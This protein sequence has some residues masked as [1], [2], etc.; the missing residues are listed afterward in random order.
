M[1][2]YKKPRFVGRDVVEYG[3][4]PQ[5]ERFSSRDDVDLSSAYLKE[6]NLVREVAGGEEIFRHEGK[7]YLHC[8]D[9]IYG[10]EPIRWRVYDRSGDYAYL[11]AER[12]LFQSNAVNERELNN[13]L[14]GYF[15]RVAIGLDDRCLVLVSL[16]NSKTSVQVFAPSRIDC[17]RM[18]QKNLCNRLDN[19]IF[20]ASETAFSGGRNPRKLARYFIRGKVEEIDGQGCFDPSEN[21]TAAFRAAGYGAGVRPCIVIREKNIER[22][23]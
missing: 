1:N 19:P 7:C 23:S 14:N 16:S 17:Q 18:L 5:D 9:G 2:Y 21:G 12:V 13:E 20:A 10:Y 22:R 11:I 15:R 3:Y 4:F 6:E 8:K